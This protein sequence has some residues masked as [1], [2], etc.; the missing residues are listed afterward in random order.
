LVALISIVVLV[1]LGLLWWWIVQP[2]GNRGL[3]DRDSQLPLFT[4]RT[5]G[6]G[7]RIVTP[8]FG[9]AT[10]SDDERPPARPGPR[11]VAYDEAETLVDAEARRAAAARSGRPATPTAP[12][13]DGAGNEGAVAD[14][15]GSAPSRNGRAAAARRPIVAPA[16]AADGR[17]GAAAA[18]AGTTPASQPAGAEPAEERW[19]RPASPPLG[20]TVQFLPGRLEVLQGRTM[21]GQEVR[22]VRPERPGDRAIVTFGRGEGAPYRHVQLNV[23]TVSRLHAR[24]ALEPGS[25]SWTLENLSTTNPVAVNGQDLPEGAAPVRL[26][27]GDRVEMGE[28]VFIFRAR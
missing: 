9:R 19:A 13:P 1:A 25:S 28:V 21:S 10:A 6:R 27:D 12:S 18:A 20:G 11:A 23:P 15:P 26:S 22:F 4:S 8:A 7:V 14:A 2:Q 16:G 5:P 17:R 24:M 3:V